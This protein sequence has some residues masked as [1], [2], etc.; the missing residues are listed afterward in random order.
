MVEVK[1]LFINP[2][3]E[4]RRYGQIKKN[5]QCLVHGKI[6]IKKGEIT[7]PVGR[8]PWNKERFG[9]LP[10]GRSAETH[11][12]V[13]SY[14][15]NNKDIFSFVDVFPKTGRTHQ[16]RIHMKYLG[17]PLVADDFYAGRKTSRDDK[18]WC[19]RLFLH[20]QSITFAHPETSKQLTFQAKLPS[21]L[22]KVLQKLTL[23]ES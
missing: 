19:S 17:Y 2:N 6:D 5:Y 14:Y 23:L 3:I 7:V 1:S 13:I 12:E 20:A 4:S 22:G 21:D 16:I 11:Y 10:G 8:L 18:V 9:V 15:K